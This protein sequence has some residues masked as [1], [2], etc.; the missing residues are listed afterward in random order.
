[1][2]DSRIDQVVAQIRSCL[3]D[4]ARETGQQEMPSVTVDTRLYGSRSGLDSL[5]LVSLMAD[6]EGR[7]AET[8]GVDLILADERAMSQTR[9]PFRT[10]GTLAEYI[11][12]LL[13]DSIPR[14]EGPGKP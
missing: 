12:G 11:V 1:M 6:L 10:V 3:E 7:L 13:D 4:L 5:R 2:T 14:K 9:S 8:F